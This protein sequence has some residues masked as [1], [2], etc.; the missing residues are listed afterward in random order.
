MLALG[1]NQRLE[2]GNNGGC[3]DDAVTMVALATPVRRWAAADLE[4][5]DV[6][7]L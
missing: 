4:L 1:R 5:P 6:K 2:F 7:L 3:A